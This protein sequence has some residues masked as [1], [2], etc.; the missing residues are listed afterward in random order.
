MFYTRLLSVP[1]P[2]I[3]LNG[4]CVHTQWITYLTKVIGNDSGSQAVHAFA[5]HVRIGVFVRVLGPVASHRDPGTTEAAVVD[6]LQCHGR[7]AA[8][9]RAGD[10]DSAP[11]RL[12]RP[13]GHER[14]C[15]LPEDPRPAP[16]ERLFFLLRHLEEERFQRQQRRS[17]LGE[18]N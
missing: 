4:D 18:S 9:S 6:Q 11:A 16:E 15:Q 17:E 5:G 14:R 12:I 3:C 10:D 2:G 8:A 1:V 7:L 13:V